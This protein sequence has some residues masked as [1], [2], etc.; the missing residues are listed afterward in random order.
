MLVDTEEQ[1]MLTTLFTVEAYTS[2]GDMR[3]WPLTCFTV[4]SDAVRLLCRIVVLPL[5]ERAAPP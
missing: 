4:I 5:L 3:V 2:A 1:L